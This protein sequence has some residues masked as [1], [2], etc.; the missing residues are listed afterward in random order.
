M[1][2]RAIQM[3]VLGVLLLAAALVL[4]ACQSATPTT[5]PPPP[6]PTSAPAPTQPPAAP[7]PTAAPTKPAL[8]VPFQD[9]WAA[10][11]HG[12]TK[13]EAFNHWNTAAAGATPA[14]PGSCATCHSSGGLAEFVTTGKTPKDQPIGGTV[15]CTTCHNDATRC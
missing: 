12:D 8:A 2:R 13:A 9:L 3:I 14:V 4:A 6:A 5:P 1:T 7:T 10:S 15:T 11:G